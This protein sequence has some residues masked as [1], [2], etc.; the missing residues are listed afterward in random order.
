MCVYFFFICHGDYLYDSFDEIEPRSSTQIT[1]LLLNDQRA[2][3]NLA[4]NRTIRK[5]DEKK[6]TRFEIQT[7]LDLDRVD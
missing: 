7:N 3:A 1:E 6:I 4:L 2:N 5:V